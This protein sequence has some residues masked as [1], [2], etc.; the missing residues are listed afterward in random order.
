MVMLVNP[1]PVSHIYR[2]VSG[3]YRRSGI[4]L[5]LGIV[6]I[7]P[8]ARKLQIDLSLLQLRLLQAEEVGIKLHEYIR[9]PLA[10]HGPQAVNIP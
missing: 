2:L 9:E 5:L 6:P 3:E 7:R 8:V 4:S 1:Y 10:A